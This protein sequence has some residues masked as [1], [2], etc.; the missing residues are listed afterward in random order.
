MGSVV[1]SNFWLPAIAGLRHE[2]QIPIHIDQLV[3]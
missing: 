1:G 2:S 3:A